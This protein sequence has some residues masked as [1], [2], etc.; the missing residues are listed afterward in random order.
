MFTDEE[1]N[2]TK[3][4]Q[5]IAFEMNNTDVYRRDIQMDGVFE[6]HQNRRSF[7][8]QIYC[9]NNYA[10]EIIEGT[11][12]N[13]NRKGKASILSLQQTTET[14]PFITLRTEKQTYFAPPPMNIFLSTHPSAIWKRAT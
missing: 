7:V 11:I 12:I 1:N 6:K 2:K 4:P 14:L 9:P 5:Q 3:T 8:E 13:I 10:D